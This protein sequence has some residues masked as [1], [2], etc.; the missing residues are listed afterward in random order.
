MITISINSVHNFSD[1]QEAAMAS[2]SWSANDM[3]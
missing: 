3:G 1:I 2:A